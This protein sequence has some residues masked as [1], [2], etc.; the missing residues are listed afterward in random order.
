MANNTELIGFVRDFVAEN[1]SRN[2]PGL[3]GD[4]TRKY[5][6]GRAIGRFQIDWPSGTGAR[7]FKSLPAEVRNKLV[8]DQGRQYQLIRENAI[9]T[10]DEMLRLSEYMKTIEGQSQE[11]LFYGLTFLA[12]TFF[13]AKKYSGPQGPSKEFV[14]ILL[15]MST[16]RGPGYVGRNVLPRL[17]PPGSD[18]PST[19]SDLLN[20]EIELLEAAGRAEGSAIILERR[21]RNAKKLKVPVDTL[22]VGRK[23]A[24]ILN[25]LNFAKQDT[26]MK[27]SIVRRVRNALDY[28]LGVAPPNW[29]GGSS[30]IMETLRGTI[31][32]ADKAAGPP[33]SLET[34][35][36]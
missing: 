30:P 15:D 25:G 26:K 22:L 19:T 27:R 3:I 12:P 36:E 8:P 33:A 9:P 14:A 5:P 11:E 16:H 34:L 1:E 13:T 21:T 23:I 20:I 31:E 10:S 18:R 29:R 17:A 4:R 24:Q 6:N 7:F 32:A 2:T 28:S 35:A